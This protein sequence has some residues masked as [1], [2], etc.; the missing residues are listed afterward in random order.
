MC[1]RDRYT[2]S[3]KSGAASTIT[4]PSAN[5]A[6]IG[7][8]TGDIIQYSVAGNTVPTYNSVTAKTSTSISLE[9][10]SDVTNVCSGALP[11]ADTTVNDLF[12]VTLE[13]KNNSKAFLFSDLTKNNVA[14]VDTNGA[15]LIIKKSYNITVASNAF[16]GTLETDADLTLEPFD[17]EDYNLTFKTTGI[18]EPL[19]NQKLTV[20]GRTVTLSGLDTASGAAVLTVTWK[21][22][23]V[24][25]KS[26]VFKRATTY[27][28]N[29]SSKTQSGTGLM[30]LN[31][32]LTYNTNYGDRV[33]DRRLSLGVCDVAY[34]LAVLESS[35]TSDPQ[36][37]VLQ[38]TNLNSNILNALQGEAMV[39][40]TSGASAIFVS[41]NGTNEVDFVYQ[42]E[43]TFEVGEEVTFEETN[44]QG[45]VQTFVPGDKDIQNNF[46]FDPG[47]QLDYVDYSAIV[48]RSG[49]EAPTRRI[50]IIYNNY[51][52]DAADPGDFV[53]V[54]SYD[55]KLYKDSLPN[56]G[57]LYAS[58]IIDLRPRVTTA[59]AGRSPAEFLARQFVP[60]TSSTTNIIARDKNFNISYDYYVGRIDKLFLL[61]LIHI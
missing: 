43:N 56:V 3:A 26:K 31:D 20:S 30:K 23:N 61:S 53:T 59:V 55:S 51:V 14:S 57:G 27:T 11:S 46:E 60:G 44:V 21:K 38:L 4:S 29:K 42:N 41:T 33:Q 25:P 37:P 32:G 34:V 10:I 40:R 49:T 45:I 16:S 58:D 54:N 12:K 36:F 50:T 47:Q 5:F 35:T 52:I 2:I 18:V 8:K 7:I 6:N 13:V 24:K 1:I 28:I 39:G 22:V 17:E 19:T 48:R 9:A 15:D